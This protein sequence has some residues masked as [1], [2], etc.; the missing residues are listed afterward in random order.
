[1]DKN[2]IL[3]VGVTSATEHEILKY[4]LQGLEKSEKPY[5]V[6]TPNPEIVVFATQH[7]KFK[8]ILNIARLALCD[9][10]G[11]FLAGRFLGKQ[12]PERAAGVD[13]MEKLCK[14]ISKQPI[15]V[16]FLGGRGKVAERV[17]ECLRS[18]CPGLRVGF[19]GSEW[20]TDKLPKSLR[21]P[22]DIL[23]V[24]Y[25][26]P[27]QEEWMAEHVDKGIFRVAIGVGGAFDYISG[28]VPRA[29]LFLRSLGLEWLFR[30]II[31]PWRWKRQLA[32]LEFVLLVLREKF[33]GR[34][35]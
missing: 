16:G 5:Y 11:V 6:V 21:L 2:F 3:G 17:S 32:L 9:G 23:F 34:N 18:K 29:P 33:A 1:M 27:R 8:E 7:P 4:I 25:G 22:I 13:L 28:S 19:A 10:T 12:F 14:A 31:Q 35:S 24:A 20:H 15:N 30:L 26:F